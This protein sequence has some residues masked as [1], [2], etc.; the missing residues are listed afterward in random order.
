LAALHSGRPIDGDVLPG[1]RQASLSVPGT[2]QSRR[3]AS[4]TDGRSAGP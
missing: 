3:Q 1:F 4:A 2:G